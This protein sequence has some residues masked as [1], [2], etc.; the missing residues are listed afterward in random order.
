[1]TLADGTSWTMGWLIGLG[2]VGSAMTG[3]MLVRPGPASQAVWDLQSVG[4][5]SSHSQ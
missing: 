5:G 4:K 2:G 1:M 3:F